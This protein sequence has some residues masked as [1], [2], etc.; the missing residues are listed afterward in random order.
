MKKP[1][2]TLLFSKLPFTI[3]GLAQFFGREGLKRLKYGF[4]E[5]F[6]KL[7]VFNFWAKAC[8]FQGSR[9]F[10]ALAIKFI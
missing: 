7:K 10:L 9:F 2:H 6:Q 4:G 3:L 8:T 1:Q 5:N